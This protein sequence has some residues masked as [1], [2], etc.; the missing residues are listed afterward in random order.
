MLINDTNKTVFVHIPKCAG[1]SV[2]EAIKEYDESGGKFWHVKKHRELGF[3]EYAHIPLFILREYFNE[4]YLKIINYESFAVVRDP[5]DRFPSSFSQHVWA[6]DRRG[7]HDFK[8]MELHSRVDAAIKLLMLNSDAES[9]LTYDY[10]HFQRQVNFVFD[11]GERLV[12]HIYMLSDVSLMLGEIGERLGVPASSTRVINASKLNQAFVFRSDMSRAV[13]GVAKSVLSPLLPGFVRRG[14]AQASKNVF[15]VHRDKKLND[16]FGSNTVVDFIS[17]Y[18]RDDIV[19]V[20]EI[21]D[22]D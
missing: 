22:S 6:S 2:R 15:F 5:F 9:Y 10:I 11:R 13:Y 14:L 16:V 18:Y 17:D 3:I 12:D 19:L 20:N 4:D 21:A 8:K 1:V 7:I